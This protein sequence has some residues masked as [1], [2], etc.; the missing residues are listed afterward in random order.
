MSI[1]APTTSW[2]FGEQR[3]RVKVGF[4][5]IDGHGGSV[6]QDRDLSP[7]PGENDAPVNAV[8]G[9]QTTN[10]DTAKVFSS[11]QW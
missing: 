3:H 1:P 9:T 7:S 8:P 5:I 11:V 10:E 2:Q 4:N 6:A